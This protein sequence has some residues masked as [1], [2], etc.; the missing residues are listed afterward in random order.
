MRVH[1]L[2]ASVLV[3]ACGATFGLAGPAVAGSKDDGLTLL[4]PSLASMLPVQ[5]GWIST[6]WQAD[7]DVCD[8]RATLTGSGAKVTYPESTAAFSSFSTA[9]ALAAGKHRL[10]GVPR[11]G[12]E[13]G[14][15][16][17]HDD[18]ERGL[19]AAA[20]GQIKKDDDLKTKKVNCSG[21]KGSQTLN[22]T[23]PVTSRT[24][25]AITVKP[26]RCW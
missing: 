12:S 8:M 20:P 16:A 6:I 1:V 7:Q 5:Q 14:D 22:A 21:P 4:V 3:T 17:G 13:H 9:S 23:L 2:A 25:A 18:P 15:R 24:A 19:P 11:H 10:H 26:H